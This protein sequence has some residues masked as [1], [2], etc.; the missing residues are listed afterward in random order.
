MSV[1]CALVALGVC[2]SAPAFA[3][4]AENATA[5]EHFE[6]GMAHAEQ[7]RWVPAL[8]SFRRSLD[9]AEMPVTLFNVASVLMRLGRMREAVETLE[10]F[11]TL[12][13]D[14]RE[15]AEARVLIEQARGAIRQVA[16]GVDPEDA[17]LTLD[18]ND[19][20]GSGPER[21]LAVDPG[22]HALTVRAVG[23][24]R[25]E[26]TIEPETERLDI[27]LTPQ[28]AIVMVRASEETA[29]I[30]I[31]GVEEGRG[32]ARLELDHGRYQLRVE[33]GDEF[34]PF[35]SALELSPGERMDVEAA[36]SRDEPVYRRGWFWA[37]IAATAVVI[38]GVITGAVLLTGR[39]EAPSGG[40]TGWVF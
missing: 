21:T 27:R 18:G 34:A 20:D 12:A 32:E 25:E 35:E 37:V 39:E 36:L 11:V 29:R 30:L 40:S 5:R 13:S 1:R 24:E 6:E 15:R 33:A 7:E 19:Q 2:F 8:E 26:R 23:Y 3:Q 14:P 38:A 10:R 9:V 28:P 4:D 16:V 17:T 31:N 22:T